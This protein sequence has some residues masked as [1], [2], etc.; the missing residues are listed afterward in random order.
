MEIK[1]PVQLTCSVRDYDG[2]PIALA[3]T[4]D[5]GSVVVGWKNNGWTIVPENSFTVHDVIKSPEAIVNKDLFS[6]KLNEYIIF[7][8]KV[9][10]LPSSMEVSDKQLQIL[11]KLSKEQFEKIINK[12]EGLLSIERSKEKD[13]NSTSKKNIKIIFNNLVSK[14]QWTTVITFIVSAYILI[15]ILEYIF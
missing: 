10:N 13:S 7:G 1:I 14:Y 9:S 5:E 2:I 6:E 3:K 4:T 11:N 15:K 8:D 12:Y